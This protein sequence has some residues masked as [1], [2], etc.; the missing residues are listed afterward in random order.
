MKNWWSNTSLKNKL[1]IPTQLVILLILIMAQ[2]WMMGQFEAQVVDEA[3]QKA[4]VAADG[5]INGL[6]IMMLNGTISQP[7]QRKL[8]MQKMGASE[9]I[10]ELRVIR[11]KSVQDQFGAGLPEEQVQDDLDR[12]VLEGGRTQFKFTAG[13]GKDSLRAVVPFIAKKDFRGTDCLQC[14]TVQEGTVN[15]AASITIDMSDEFAALSKVSAILWGGQVLMQAVLFLVIG[16]V[17]NRGLRPFTELQR[18]MLAMQADGNL[19]R[20]VNVQSN[21]E[22]G[23][24]AAAF[25][26]LMD[27]FSS[28]IGQVHATVQDVAGTATQLATAAMQ[29]TRSS[30]AQS[31]VAASTAAAVEQMTVSIT[32]VAESADEV[33]KL[34]EQSLQQTQQGNESAG[35][36]TLEIASIE[37][38]VN[39]IAASVGEFVQSARTIASMTKQVRDIAEQTNLLALNAAIEA[40]RAG[41]QGRGFAVVADEVRKL[42]ERSAQSASEID[43]VTH[44]LDGQSGSVENAIEQGLQSLQSTRQHVDRVFS[45]LSQAGVSVTNASRGVSDIA[46]SVGEQSKASNDIARHVESIA[47]MADE[48]HTAIEHVGQDIM[49]L[50]RLAENMQVAV[51]RFKV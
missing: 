17:I 47:Q 28:M 49:R 9:H 11:G 30:Q 12:A 31:E 13:E 38:A 2:R 48:N 45:V 15:G 36:M 50:E 25:N 43:K 4:V 20:R 1:Q 51:A 42:A 33:R 19:S 37:K 5:V 27:G 34:S 32:S 40:A 6:N 39:Q 3:K 8:F 10:L 21:D 7:D 41:E 29:I 16:W 23:Q 26:T 22:V 46:T 35:V 18:T 14:H 24:A 44:T